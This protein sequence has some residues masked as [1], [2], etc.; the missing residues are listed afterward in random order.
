M[1]KLLLFL[2]KTDDEQILNHFNEYTV[3]HL[4]GIAGEEIKIASVESNLLL[5]QKFSKFCEITTE[6]KDMW[7]KL[8]NTKAGRE[9]NKDLMDFHQSV[10]LIFVDYQK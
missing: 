8:M 3:K 2:N 7:D 10:T 5:D 4:S 6:S 9:L 1:Y